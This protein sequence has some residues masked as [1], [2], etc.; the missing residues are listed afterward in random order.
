MKCQ[1]AQPRKVQPRSA[2]GG[3]GLPPRPWPRALKLAE[4]G[5]ELGPELRTD[6]RVENL[7]KNGVLWGSLF[8]FSR[9][10]LGS[11]FFFVLMGFIISF[12]LMGFDVSLGGKISRKCLVL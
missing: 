4:P 1:E 7:C 6:E 11:M 5:A 8:F 12:F 2:L 10:L 3:P 9:D